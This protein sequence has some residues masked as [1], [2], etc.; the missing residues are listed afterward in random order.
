M[1]LNIDWQA[2][3]DILC[4]FLYAVDLPVNSKQIAAMTEEGS[5]VG[6]LHTAPS[7][8]RWCAMLRVLEMKGRHTRE[9]RPSPL[10]N[11]IPKTLHEFN[12]G[13]ME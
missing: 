8:C 4:C 9:S 2:S 7:G 10:Q 12:P 5:L 13:Y 6:E 11:I 1:P 3:G